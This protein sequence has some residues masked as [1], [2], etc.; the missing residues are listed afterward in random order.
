MNNAPLYPERWRKGWTEDGKER[1]WSW[2]FLGRLRLWW[3]R[4]SWNQ[5]VGCRATSQP[6]K[7]PPTDQPTRRRRGSPRDASRLRAAARLR[8]E[9]S[10][11]ASRYVRHQ[12]SCVLFVLSSPYP[13][14]IGDR[15]YASSRD[16]R[17]TRFSAA[18]PEAVVRT[19][20]VFLGLVS[21]QYLSN[22]RAVVIVIEN[23]RYVD[24]RQVTSVLRFTDCPYLLRHRRSLHFNLS[25]SRE[26]MAPDSCDWA[27]PVT[28]RRSSEEEKR[29]RGISGTAT[30]NFESQ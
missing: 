25:E 8:C 21:S 17:Y 15:R 12:T 1:T 4:E 5:K 10:C 2:L 11:F 29:L 19:W 3:V 13:P 23:R 30:S 26:I 14:L 16:R 6:S 7:R 18:V 22:N 27:L 28:S 9:P 20:V 24:R